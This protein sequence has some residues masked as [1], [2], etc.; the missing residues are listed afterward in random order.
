MTH[1]KP[2]IALG[3]GTAL[4][5][6][7][8]ACGGS[9]D[10]GPHGDGSD[11]DSGGGDGSG[12]TQFASVEEYFASEVKPELGFCRTCHVPGGA[13]DTEDG[14]RFM[15]SKDGA[16]DYGK[17]LEA[18]EAL[19]GG[20]ENNRILT[21]ASN[22]DEQPHS[23]GAPWP[24]DSA[25]Y[26]AMRTVLQC[27]KDPENC[28]E[29]VGGDGGDSKPPLLGNPGKHYF[30]N[31][32]CDGAPD[33]KPIDWSQD[34]RRMLREEEGLIG[35]D[36]YAVH[37]ND[38]YELC[39]TETL[40]Q[41]QARQNELRAAQGEE[42]VY[43][44][45]RDPA[46]C[47]EWRAAVQRG[48]D[49]IAEWPTDQP[50]AG[51][52]QGDDFAKTDA[53]NNLWN[54]WG[55][56][57]RPENYDL[58]LSQR[59]GLAPAPDHIKNPYP[60]PGEEDEL[61]ASFGG[62]GKL[63][64]GYAQGRDAEGNYNGTMSPTCF[65]CHAGQIGRGQVAGHGGG[66]SPESYGAN[67]D[68]TFMGLPNSNNELG[69]LIV[70]LL[71]ARQY[72]I[73]GMENLPIKVP[74][75]GYIPIINTTRGTNA[76][77]TETESMMLQRDFD[78]LD[79]NHVFAYP[80]HANAGDQDPPAWWWLHNKT[81][82]L[83]FGG[84]STD[85]SRGNMY[86]GSVNSLSGD[87][88]KANEEI[89]EDVH[90]WTLTVEAPD[91]PQGF[92]T[93][94][95]GSRAPGDKPG[96]ID[97]Q[98]A[99]QG[100][101]LFHEKNLWAGDKNEDIPRPKGSGSCAGC[102]GAYSP[103][104]IND[105]RFLPSPELAGMTGYTVP[106]EI[107]QTDSATA[108]AWSQETRKHLS[109]FWWS[110]PD[111]VEGY[112]LPENKDGLTEVLDDYMMADFQGSDFAGKLD[113]ALNHM[114]SLQPAGDLLSEVG[115]ELLGQIPAMA[116]GKEQAGRVTGACPISDVIGYV[117]P[118]LHG[119]W[120]S[121]PYFHNASVPTVWDVLKPSERPKVWRRQRSSTQGVHF[122]QFE[123]RLSGPNGGYNFEKLGWNYDRIRCSDG[124]Q[125]I[126]YYDCQPEND[127]PPELDWVVDKTFGGLLWPTWIVP[128]PI[129]EEGLEHR[130]IFNTNMYSK[131]N[132]GHEWTKVLTDQ[133]RR[134][135]IEY[136]KT[137]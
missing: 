78:T 79:K 29:L 33:S 70:D 7:L 137:L 61:T 92:C 13:G 102:H 8:T 132:S 90:Q 96:C 1:K 25:P 48:H 116:P 67:P 43:S 63:P 2:F 115:N 125:G 113:R 18:W 28:A 50:R 111:A 62:S 83:W 74:S 105:E 38:P 31:Q 21:K 133:E 60:L 14:K 135:L 55:M 58:Q 91:Y 71:N 12:G 11:N 136:L 117:T 87:Q 56:D 88:V 97:R 20:V 118:P 104:Y 23:G 45:K 121:A 110:Y 131:D 69:V 95:D 24:V 10:G 53:W 73:P 32:I 120:A 68:G 100:A 98:L 106:I 9:S 103:R 123:T 36:E 109:T 66:D 6:F 44:A 27:W 108:E 41:T 40:F 64:L 35:S 51:D 22:T 114:G 94:E 129:G 124:G 16:H 42:Q 122:N 76:A 81:R 77:D 17:V 30:V 84:H 75:F 80:L 126:P 134:A 54:V 59:Y 46:T 112:R 130:M 99:R 89:F 47:G 34:P 39:H 15:L 101:V 128:P 93:G 119:V 107:I 85:S 4:A 5:L 82:Y 127:M 37:F 26:N 19:G 52:H 3:A 57:E 65:L 72:N 49:W 86:F